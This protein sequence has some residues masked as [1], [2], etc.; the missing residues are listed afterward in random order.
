MGLL[1]AQVLCLAM[2]IAA[3]LHPDYRPVTE[4]LS[5]PHLAGGEIGH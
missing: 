4:V 5:L 3:S 1:L 2:Q